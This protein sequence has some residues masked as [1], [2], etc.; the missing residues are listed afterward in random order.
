MKTTESALALPQYRQRAIESLQSLIFAPQKYPQVSGLLKKTSRHATEILGKNIDR[1][2]ECVREYKNNQELGITALRTLVALRDNKDNSDYAMDADG[3]LHERV[4]I[5]DILLKQQFWQ[6]DDL[7]ELIFEYE[8]EAEQN[9]WLQYIDE[10][11]EGTE[12][13][14][15]SAR[16]AISKLFESKSPAAQNK[17]ASVVRWEISKYIPKEDQAVDIRDAWLESTKKDYV[18]A[19][20]ARN[21]FAIRSLEQKNQGS[22]Q[23]LY[24]EFGIRD[25]AR[26]PEELLVSQDKNRNDA[27]TPYGVVIYPRND[28]NGAFYH[29]GPL[30]E[31]Y[32]DLQGGYHTRIVEAKGKIDIARKL[33]ELDRR[34]GAQH[35]IS[36]AIL[37]GHGTQDS[38]RFGD[39]SHHKT[40]K[41]FTEDLMG[42]GVRRTKHFFEENPTIILDSCSTGARAGIGQKLS[43]QIGA[44]VIAPDQPC[45]TKSLH[46]KVQQGKLIIDAEYYDTETGLPVKKHSY[47]KG[48][49]EQ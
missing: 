16:H 41:L 39:Y 24:E 30:Q 23:R 21:L 3:L 10:L 36:F 8:N 42:Y 13:Q 28:H 4:A 7:L 34:Y 38:I 5:V 40:D 12:S 35:K 37:G 22:V 45:N 48:F 46:G 43:Q 31:L 9:Q 29:P 49:E 33:I 1:I 32:Q 20:I 14:A 19:I 47:I 25:F 11:F 18:P 17:G 26:Y 27:S 6:R 15:F 2:D 44:R